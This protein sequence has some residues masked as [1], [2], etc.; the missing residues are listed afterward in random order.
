[1]NQSN[2]HAQKSNYFI[3]ETRDT[4]NQ[5]IESFSAPCPIKPIKSHSY[6]Y[7]LTLNI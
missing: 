6:F 2:G 7:S 5:S 1:M 4:Y 3:L